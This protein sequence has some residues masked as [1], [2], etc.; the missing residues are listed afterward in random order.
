MLNFIQSILF[1]FHS[2]KLIRIN[3]FPLITCYLSV[4]VMKVQLPT[5]LQ[6]NLYAMK[7]FQIVRVGNGIVFLCMLA[8]S[9]VVSGNVI[10]YYPDCGDEKLKLLF[11]CKIEQCT[12]IRSMPDINILFCFEGAIKAGDTFK[13]N[14]YLS[15]IVQPIKRK[16][17]L[18]Q[19]AS[20][21]KKNEIFQ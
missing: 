10:S 1:S 14:H 4:P 11:N 8:L 19:T 12:A 21:Q 13:V 16:R 20:I 2:L 3:L 15:L 7:L 9:S 5:V 18:N 17:K 6:K